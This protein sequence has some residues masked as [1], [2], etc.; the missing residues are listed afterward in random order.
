MGRMYNFVI[1][2]PSCNRSKSDTL[3]AKPH[4]MRWLEFIDTHDNDLKEIGFEAGIKSDAQTTFSV[5]RW[6]YSNALSSNGQAWVK[7]A[8]YEPLES[9]YLGLWA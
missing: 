1:A 3:A 6:G 2:H 9:S 5:A 4:L 8:Q 7:S